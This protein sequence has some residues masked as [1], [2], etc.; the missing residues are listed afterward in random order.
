MGEGEKMAAVIEEGGEAAVQDL[1][2]RHEG[3]GPEL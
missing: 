3:V 1:G 2:G